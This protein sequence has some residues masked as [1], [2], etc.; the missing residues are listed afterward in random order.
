MHAG[1][2]PAAE[3]ESRDFGPRRRWL[4]HCR[5]GGDEDRCHLDA[6]DHESGVRPA[7]GSDG[8]PKPFVPPRSRRAPSSNLTDAEIKYVFGVHERTNGVRIHAVVAIG[9]A[10]GSTVQAHSQIER[11]YRSRRV[12]PDETFDVEGG[13]MMRVDH[14]ARTISTFGKSVSF[15]RAP[16]D[17]V[18][19][20]LEKHYPGY[21]LDIQA[22]DEIR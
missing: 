11:L 6:P 10:F 8:P 2:G 21:T 7:A 19:R 18:R 4:G 14:A 3:T 5:T 16:V 15:G 17:E 20:V 13:G 9:R 1:D 12:K 22:T